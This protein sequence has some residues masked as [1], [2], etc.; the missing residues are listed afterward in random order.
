MRS[1]SNYYSSGIKP[2]IDFLFAIVLL[3]VLLPLLLLIV[4]VS[5]LHFRANPIFVQKRIGL[6]H[7]PFNMYKFRTYAVV[8]KSES[9]T[10]FGRC[11]RITSFDEL[12]Q[13][14]NVING[15]M[16]F[17]G[18]RPLLPE[19]LDFYTNDELHRHQVKP[20][21]SGLAQIKLGNSSDWSGRMKLDLE[22]V[23]T[24][25]F[26][27]DFKIAFWTIMKV[28]DFRNRRKEDVEIESFSEFAQR[29]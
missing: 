2:L 11:L 8:G 17:I 20:G 5:S 14:L 23:S 13:L 18:P 12:P 1:A 19:Y 26:L 28:V 22:Y 24:Q 27:I 3:T 7:K 9:I 15:S 21:L 10:F 16:S 4:T 25:S 29:R 6:G